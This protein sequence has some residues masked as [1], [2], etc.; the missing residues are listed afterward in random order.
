[1]AYLDIGIDLGTTTVIANDSQ[2]NTVITE[3]SLIA[4]DT[5]N[6]KAIAIGEAVYRMVGR[7]PDYIRVVHPLEDGVI[8]DFKMTELI[9]RHLLQKICNNQLVKPRVALCVPSATTPVESQAVI[10]AA[11]AAGARNVYLIE[12]PVAAAIG[13]GVNLSLPNGNLI[14]DVGGGTSDIAVLSL[15][16]IVCKSS[17]KVA[18]QKFDEA[19]AKYVRARYNLLVGEKKAEQ[20]K[21][22]IASVDPRS[23]ERTAD[24]KGRDLL[25]GLPKKI[26]VTRSELYP[27]L[28]EVAEEI[29]AAVHGVME[30]TPPELVGDIH[31]NGI[32]L[33][34]GGALIDGLDRVMM[35]LL[36]VPVHVADNAKECVAIGTAKSF[37]Y[38]DRLFDGFVMPSTHVH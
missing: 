10:D 23:P 11:V 12:E 4:V 18:G 31:T 29:V 21:I 22:E 20:V 5:R 26:P 30:R 16:G 32:I 17:I 8:S 36:K 7:T 15:N 13:A 24:V 38:L 28:R 9:I 37:E 25:G 3:P 1:M 14:V 27:S 35:E 19:L 34:G 6:G 33:T 2:R